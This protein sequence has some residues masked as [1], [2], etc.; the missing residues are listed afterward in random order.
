MGRMFQFEDDDLDS[1][2]GFIECFE[3]SGGGPAGSYLPGTHLTPVFLKLGLGDLPDEAKE[4]ASQATGGFQNASF[5]NEETLDILVEEVSDWMLGKSASDRR[6]TRKQI[7]GI[8]DAE[9][10]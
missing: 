4:I 10:E 9:I 1:T 8:I 6:E 5:G 2:A 7:V 3:A